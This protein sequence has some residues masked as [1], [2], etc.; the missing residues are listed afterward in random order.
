[1]VQVRLY[2]KVTLIWDGGFSMANLQKYT[3]SATGHLTKHFERAKDINGDYIKF[4]NQDI[5]IQKSHLNYNLAPEHDQIEFIRQRCSEVQCLNRKDVNVMCSWVVTAPKNLDQGEEKVFF[6]HTYDFLANR[7]GKKNVISAYVHLDEKSPHM[8]FAFV[9]VAFDKNKGIE[10]V[11]A[12]EVITRNDLQ[13]FHKDLEKHLER[14][15]GHEVD[16]LNEATKEG[17]KSIDELKRGT[18]IEEV[19]KIK[20]KVSKIVSKAQEEAKAIED[21]IIPLQAE[22][23]AYKAYLDQAKRDSDISVMYPQYAEVSKKGLIHK[24]EYVTVPKEMWE[25]K[26]ISANEIHALERLR[27]EIEDKIKEFKKSS[28][29]ERIKTLEGELNKSKKMNQQLSK[30]L[31]ETNIKLQKMADIFKSKPELARAVSQAEKEL[32]KTK[33]HSI[34]RGR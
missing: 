17:N 23:N 26:H 10:K 12:K 34:D 3:K 9:P 25:A 1:M 16:I 21:S 2:L 24:Q 4:G 30:A 14:T 29:G 19:S 8:H 6:K 7:Y 33:I 5:D 27:N 20:Q 22:Y 32:K 18:A 31:N 15:L 28:S 11:S 13:S